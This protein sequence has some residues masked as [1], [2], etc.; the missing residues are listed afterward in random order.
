MSTCGGPY[1]FSFEVNQPDSVAIQGTFSWLRSFL[2]M[3][4]SATTKL[5]GLS[6][7]GIFLVML[8]L[9]AAAP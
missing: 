4:E 7:S 1:F 9:N 2:G 3:S 5:I 8:A 6:L